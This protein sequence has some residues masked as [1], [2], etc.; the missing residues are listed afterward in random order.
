MIR[1]I[2]KWVPVFFLL[3]MAVGQSGCKK[4]VEAAKEDLL[5]NLIT[6]NLW[7]VS[8]FKEGNTDLTNNFSVYEFKFNKDGTVYGKS[9]GQP[10]ASGTW[11][12]NSEDLSITSAFPNGP[13]PLDK[14]TG[15]W[16]ITKTTMS[17]VKSNRVQGSTTYYLDL[18]KK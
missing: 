2:I 18:I 16:M 8:N 1:K 14:L 10:D 3:V 13:S 5:M 4:A 7:L 11:K 15:K 9:A 12:G 17:S 6:D